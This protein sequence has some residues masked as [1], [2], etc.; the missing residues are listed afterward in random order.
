[1]EIKRVSIDEYEVAMP[2]YPHIF[3]SPAF[4]RAN[5][6][7]ASSLHCL[8]FMDGGRAR[9]G[10]IMGERGEKLLSPFSAPFGGLSYAHDQ[11]AELVAEAYSLL[12]DYS[13]HLSLSV[14]ITLPPAFY[15]DSMNAKQVIALCSLGMPNKTQL[16]ASFPTELFVD[17]ERCLPRTGRKNLNQARKAG[18][19]FMVVNPSDKAAAYRAYQVIA[20]NR[21]EHG[22]PLSMSWEDILRTMNV[23]DADFFLLTK[24]S[25]DVASAMVFHVSSDI[26]QVIYW[27]DRSA[28]SH[29]RSMNILAFHV[30]E[31]YAKTGISI[32]DVGPCAS[33]DGSVNYGLATFKETVGCR[34]IPRFTFYQ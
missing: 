10:I 4:A 28:W 7:K 17:Y 21:A 27:G 26:V 12:V 6:H 25:E 1:M 5:A 30:F 20:D 19:E 13:R 24:D 9:M 16:N 23:I 33:S 34:L 8:L 29:L 22:Y 2:H 18:F 14:E 11:R 31:Y 32:V 3:N 15:D